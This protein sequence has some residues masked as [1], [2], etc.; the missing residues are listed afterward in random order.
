MHAHDMKRAPV[1]F[2]CPA[3]R[4]GAGQTNRQR[5]V[6]CCVG[7][8]MACAA[9]VRCAAPP[10][11]VFLGMMSQGPQQAKPLWGVIK[12]NQGGF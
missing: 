11:Y 12:A 7:V 3:G 9:A 8:L 1:R 4:A 2:F 10:S 5:E 6:V